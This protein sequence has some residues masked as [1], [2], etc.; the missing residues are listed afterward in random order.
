MFFQKKMTLALNSKYIRFQI[1]H[2]EFVHPNE[3]QSISIC[4]DLSIYFLKTTFLT[5]ILNNKSITPTNR[6]FEQ[7]MIQKVKTGSICLI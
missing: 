5:R 1:C 3:N 4:Y 7:L 2:T 6:N